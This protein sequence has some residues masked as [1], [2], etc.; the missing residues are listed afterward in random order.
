MKTVEGVIQKWSEDEKKNF[1]M[2]NNQNLVYGKFETIYAVLSH[3]LTVHQVSKQS[4]K[5]L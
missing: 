1:K 4:D 5:K 3:G 2:C